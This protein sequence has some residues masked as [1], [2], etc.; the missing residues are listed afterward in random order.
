MTTVPTPSTRKTGLASLGQAL[1]DAHRALSIAVAMLLSAVLLALA[2][3]AR[4][5]PYNTTSEDGESRLMLR[6]HDPVAYFTQG[7]HVPGKA[8]FRSEHDGVAFRFASAE[9]KA[10]FD[11]EPE[12]YAPQY[13]GYCSNGIAYG[14][15]WSGDPDTWKIIDGKLYIFGGE[16][17]RRYFLIDEA[18]N[19]ALARKYWN[20]EVNGSI[21]FLQR[22]RR[23]IFRVPHYKTG[24]ELEDEYQR[25]LKAGEIR[26]S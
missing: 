11:R 4:A 1:I 10:T 20:D 17:S 9:H 26:P 19:A 21:G 6:G 8:E 12:K 15:P 14:I 3:D 25:R 16:A 2:P 7:K 5:G 23:L 18:R 22:V 13:G 24:K